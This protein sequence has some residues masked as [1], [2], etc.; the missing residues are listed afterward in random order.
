MRG[1]TV[2]GLVLISAGCVP[3]DAPDDGR[4]VDPELARPAPEVGGPGVPRP[5]IERLGQGLERA[6]AIWIEPAADGPTTA[7]DIRA[8]LGEVEAWYAAVSGGKLQPAFDLA[9]PF[10]LGGDDALD[11]DHPAPY[12]AALDAG[13]DLGRYDRFVILQSAGWAWD[14]SREP[15]AFAAAGTTL[16]ASRTRL[17][18]ITNSMATVG[19]I[20]KQ[21]GHTMGLPSANHLSTLNGE[22]RWYGN[23]TDVMGS[24]RRL[25]SFGAPAQHLLGWLGSDEVITT[26]SEGEYRLGAL[27][28]GVGVR[29]LRIP[30]A[31]PAGEPG[32]WWVYVEARRPIGPGAQA[33]AIYNVPAGVMLNLV[34][35]PLADPAAA[36]VEPG[37]FDAGLFTSSIDGT[38][39][40]SSLT[41]TDAALVP[42]RSIAIPGSDL[43]LSVLS[44]GEGGAQVRLLRSRSGNAAPVIRAVTATAEGDGWRLAVDAHD[45]DGDEIGAF[46]N[47]GVRRLPED[48]PDRFQEPYFYEPGTWGH[49]L[50]VHHVFPDGRPRRVTVRVA[51]GRGGE[52]LG[53]VDLAGHVNRAPSIVEIVATRLARDRF[54]F[55]AAID[56]QD[57]DLLDLDWD[58]AGQ[59]RSDVVKPTFTFSGEGLHQVTLTVRD[60]E[61]S[62]TGTV[63]VD[64]RP[65][66]NQAP[67]PAVPGSVETVAGEW[68]WL[69][70][71]ASV[72]P[73]AYPSPLRFTWTLPE[74]VEAGSPLAGSRLRVRAFQE[75]TREIRVSVSDGEAAVEAVI[76]L[77]VLPGA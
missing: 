24:S 42:G 2:A 72:D 25:G 40:T 37:S 56:D 19:R 36:G 12:E 11:I 55:S 65:R 63:E 30:V 32:T 67:V 60:G 74:G 66:D 7:E 27:E 58:L 46:W 50:T 26:V 23:L 52:A 57:G 17:T 41:S 18:Q 64:T 22:V 77:L 45:P 38:P 31:A 61:L 10:V 28:S 53:F 39:D 71:S 62:A 13:F 44:S 21:I 1:A 43:Y 15:A 59:G 5:D 47:L 68:I 76:Q 54:V 34:R 29:A 4:P 49:G 35:D 70:A 51:D 73:D 48:N 69:D 9:G 3:M 75:G 20:V 8:V 16:T 14:E 6:L 33:A